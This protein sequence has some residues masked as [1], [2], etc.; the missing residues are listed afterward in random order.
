MASWCSV[1]TAAVFCLTRLGVW[2]VS[3][4]KGFSIPAGLDYC[5]PE[6]VPGQANTVR[7]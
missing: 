3:E 1:G 7:P 4:V 6:M 5:A 2:E